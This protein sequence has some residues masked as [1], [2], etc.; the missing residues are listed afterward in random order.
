MHSLSTDNLI[1]AKCHRRAIFDQNRSMLT[2][3]ITLSGIRGK[4]AKQTTQL[5]I[6]IVHVLSRLNV[7]I[8]E[9]QKARC[10]YVGIYLITYS[11]KIQY[12]FLTFFV[13]FSTSLF[14]LC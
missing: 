11:F 3:H 4:P 14:L 6:G 9:G 2:Q 12:L 10:R 5:A 8:L 7:V 1:V 13:V